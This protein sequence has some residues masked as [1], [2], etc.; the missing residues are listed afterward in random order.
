[1][2]LKKKSFSSKQLCNLAAIF[3]SFWQQGVW[4]SACIVKSTCLKIF[5]DNLILCSLITDI[6]NMCKEFDAENISLY[7]LKQIY[8]FIHCFSVPGRQSLPCRDI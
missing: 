8:I 5:V 4:D 2:M 3:G 6:L 1:M 7:N